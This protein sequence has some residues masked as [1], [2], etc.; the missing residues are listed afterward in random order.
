MALTTDRRLTKPCENG[1]H[2]NIGVPPVRP[3]YNPERPEPT[4]KRRSSSP[5]GCSSPNPLRGCQLLRRRFWP[6][7]RVA[8][9][10][11]SIPFPRHSHTETPPAPVRSGS[12][13]E[14]AEFAFGGSTLVFH[15]TN[16]RDAA[17]VPFI[18]A[19]RKA[20][21]NS[22]KRI[23]VTRDS[24]AWVTAAPIFGP[25]NGA[26]AKGALAPRRRNVVFPKRP[27]ASS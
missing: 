25:E 5:R 20:R 9:T 21:S 3:G 14:L 12:E 7:P 27:F 11:R 2:D 6:F 15:S 26:V 1:Y 23:L 18:P 4:S 10:I 16:L 17:V 13:F 22:E 19:A 24:A 8:T